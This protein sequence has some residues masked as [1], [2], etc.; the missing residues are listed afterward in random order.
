MTG[1][2]DYTAKNHLNY[3]AGAAAMPAMPASY[4]ALFTAAGVDAGT[5]FT[6]VSGGAYART[7]ISGT[8]TTNATT[9]S[10]NNTLHF[11]SVPAWL[12]AGF[13]AY[14]LTATTV[15][16]AGTTVLSTTSTT[17]VLSA[18]LTGAGAGASDSIAFSAYSAASGSA[19][20][21]S[22]SS[23]ALATAQATASWGTVI[24]W[25]VYDASSSGNLLYWDYLGAYSW[26]PV[27]ISS[28]A[29]GVITAKGHGYSAG[30]AVVFSTEYGGTAPTF[31]QS[32]LTGLL[33][34][35]GPATDTFTVTNGGTAVNTSSTGS[36]MVRKVTQQ[37]VP[38]NATF[39]LAAGALT[40]SEA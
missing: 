16:P 30:D 7:Q 11:A 20:S 21:Q 10:G 12:V 3:L 13:T 6:E 32:T 22:T 14:D 37:L 28:A 33:A 31:S 8:L 17:V 27:E 26:L 18:N 5:G 9:A 1:L 15:I 35:V 25:G 19:P 23:A 29:P 40:L 38:A 36:G 2:S 34:V 24:A 4:L 39:N